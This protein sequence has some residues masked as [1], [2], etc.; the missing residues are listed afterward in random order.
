MKILLTLNKTYRGL[1]DMGHWYVYEPLKQLGHEVYWYDTVNPEVKN[2]NKVVEHFKPD[3]IF[4][5]LTND[6]IIASHEPWQEIIRETD[7]G[8]TKTFNWFCD[9]TWRFDKF[10]SQACHSF[11]ICSTPEPTYVEKYKSVG[12]ENILLGMW[13]ANSEFYSPRPFL[14]RDVD[15]CFIGAPNPSRNNFFKQADVSIEKIFGIS[16]EEMF[17]THANTKIGIN[18]SAN[19]NDPSGGTQMKQR[20]FE[21]AAGASTILT[22]YHK[23]IEEFFEL[24]KEIITFEAAEE[25][26]E[27]INFL[28]KN[29]KVTKQIAA[30]GHQRF[31]AEHDSKIR[32]AKI[33]KEIQEI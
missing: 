16:N 1:P 33:L 15:A 12:Y 31:L 28:S 21:I 26:K 24:D 29:D 13:H 3:L 23:G 4:C 32:L 7:S 10:S 20:I 19:Q 11:N 9:D 6:R 30:A 25:F 5:C 18:L 22:E 14:E 8:R 17:E 27:K 2:Y